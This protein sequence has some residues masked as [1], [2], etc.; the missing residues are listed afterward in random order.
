MFR[1]KWTISTVIYLFGNRVYICFNR[2]VPFNMNTESL[3]C[4]CILRMCT[5]R[6]YIQLQRM[7]VFFYDSI[8]LRNMFVAAAAIHNIYRMF[9]GVLFNSTALRVLFSA[10]FSAG[11]WLCNFMWKMT[12]GTRL[13]HFTG[14]L[15]LYLLLCL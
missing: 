1:W 12:R 8:V 7:A 5:L 3:W 6:D 14:N 13:S 9:C 4:C 11:K 2:G 10:T 15:K